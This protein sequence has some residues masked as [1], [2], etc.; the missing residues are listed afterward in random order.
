MPRKPLQK[1]QYVNQK[2]IKSLT[3]E[4]RARHLAY[5]LRLTVL[6]TSQP[7][8]EVSLKQLIGLHVVGHLT[9]YIP[10]IQLILH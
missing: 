6:V 10:L 1:S 8:T 3:V 5:T 4:N 2:F 7:R 9:V